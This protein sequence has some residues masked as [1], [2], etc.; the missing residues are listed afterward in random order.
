MSQ[1]I[2][3]TLKEQTP[4]GGCKCG[5]KTDEVPELEAAAL[6][7]AIRHPAILGALDSLRSGQMMILKVSHLPVPLLKQ[8]ERQMP[9][10]FDITYLDEGPEFWRLQ[11]VRR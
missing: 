8:I 1:D 4:T 3:I 9:D 7:K 6:P 10:A 5:V 2:A 11:F